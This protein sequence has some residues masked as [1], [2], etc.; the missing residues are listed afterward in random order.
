M[1]FFL[2]PDLL[3]CFIDL[4]FT[5]VYIRQRKVLCIRLSCKDF[6]SVNDAMLARFAYKA[7]KAPGYL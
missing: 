5:S 4:K 7:D 2:F 6:V 1:W 3:Y